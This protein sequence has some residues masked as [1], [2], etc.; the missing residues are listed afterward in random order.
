MMKL[1]I[2][3]DKA[4]NTEGATMHLGS[5]GSLREQSCGLVLASSMKI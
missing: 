1:K 5:V 3:P 2:I 4:N